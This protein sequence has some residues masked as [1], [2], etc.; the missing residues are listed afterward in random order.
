MEEAE[1][2]ER[3]NSSAPFN[4]DCLGLIDRNGSQLSA[5]HITLIK[6]EYIY[7]VLVTKLHENN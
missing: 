7:I 3:I 6:L 4:V 1:L 2:V 5:L